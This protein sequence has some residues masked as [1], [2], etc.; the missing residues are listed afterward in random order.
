MNLISKFHEMKDDERERK[1]N[2]LYVQCVT[3]QLTFNCNKIYT[4][5]F[6][7]LYTIPYLYIYIYRHTTILIPTNLLIF[8]IYSKTKKNY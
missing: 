6:V 1:K 4:S 2:L 5:L 3:K 8:K 7:Y